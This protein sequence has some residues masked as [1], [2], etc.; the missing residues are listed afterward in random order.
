MAEYIDKDET[1]K[2]F[3][4][5]SHLYFDRYYAD[6]TDLESRAKALG[7]DRAAGEIRMMLPAAV[8]VKKIR[9]GSWSNQVLIDDGFGNKRVG[10]VCSACKQFVPNKGNFCLNCGADM[11][12]DT[13][14]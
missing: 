8:D 4:K 3:I 2:K 7:Y 14:G 12:G 10:Y 6:K 9:Y 1:E 13:N 11:R 5:L